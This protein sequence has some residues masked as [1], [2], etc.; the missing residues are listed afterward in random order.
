[1]T[2]VNPELLQGLPPALA[3]RY[4]ILPRQEFLPKF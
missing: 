4:S 2:V 1:M 3:A